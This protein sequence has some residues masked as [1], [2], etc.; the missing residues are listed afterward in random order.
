M[1]EDINQEL[2]KRKLKKLLDE[3]VITDEELRNAPILTISECCG[4]D[5][6]AEYPIGKTKCS[7]CG[8]PCYGDT[9]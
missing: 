4:A 3:E 5:L 1:I 8:K 6:T 2:D 9:E 7:K